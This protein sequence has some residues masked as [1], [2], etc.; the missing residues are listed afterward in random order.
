[1]R[2]L[3]SRLG[4]VCC[5]AVAIVATASVRQLVAQDPTSGKPKISTTTTSKQLNQKALKL[6]ESKK[7]IAAKTTTKAGQKLQEFFPEVSEAHR[8]IES[9]LADKTSGDFVDTPLHDVANFLAKQHNIPIILHQISEDEGIAVTQKVSG[10]SFESLLNVLLADNDLTFEIRNDVLYI[11]TMTE[12]SEHLTNRVYPIADLVTSDEKSFDELVAAIQETTQTLWLE[13]DGD[14]G[15][16]SV[17]KATA[18]VSVLQSY[19]GHK[20]V[21]QFLRSMRQAKSAQAGILPKLARPK[22]DVTRAFKVPTLEL[23]DSVK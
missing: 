21:L 13:V 8:K 9:V 10:V 3:A 17:V 20:A 11:T 7:P 16:I 6:V 4:I 15:T 19:H 23:K 2:P 14:G 1:M 22:K 18:L 12:S 5:V